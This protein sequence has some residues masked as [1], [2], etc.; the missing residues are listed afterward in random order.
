[1]PNNILEEYNATS[2][3]R[4]DDKTEI[5]SVTTV[6]VGKTIREGV[7]LGAIITTTIVGKT[8]PKGWRAID[9]SFNLYIAKLNNV[10]SDVTNTTNWKN[11]SSGGGFDPYRIEIECDGSQELY[12]IPHN[13][14]NDAPVGS[15]YVQDAFGDWQPL[16]WTQGIKSTSPDILSFNTMAYLGNTALTKYKITIIA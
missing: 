2:E 9:G 3:Q 5:Y 11:V 4:I 10:S 15:L 16:D 8:Y 13:K 12:P 1:M 7:E 14:N 6:D